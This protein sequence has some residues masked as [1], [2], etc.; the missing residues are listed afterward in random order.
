MSIMKTESFMLN[1]T[2]IVMTKGEFTVAVTQHNNYLLIVNLFVAVRGQP[3]I[4]LAKVKESAK[5]AYYDWTYTCGKLLN[6]DVNSKYFGAPRVRE[7]LTNGNLTLDDIPVVLNIAENIVEQYKELV[8][9][10]E[11]EEKMKQEVQD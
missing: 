7:H 3:F 8:A 11:K 4:S 5:D 9:R 2:T 10:E 1:E 6:K